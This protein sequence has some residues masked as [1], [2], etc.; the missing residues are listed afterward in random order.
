MEKNGRRKEKE[1][2]GRRRKKEEEEEEEGEGE[3]EGGGEGGG[4]RKQLNSWKE[5]RAGDNS[6]HQD[7]RCIFRMKACHVQNRK[8]K[9]VDAEVQVF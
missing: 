9:K 8:G 6:R 5:G 1:E 3:E 7:R 4:G 2:E